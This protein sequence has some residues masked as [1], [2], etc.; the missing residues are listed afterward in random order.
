[1]IRRRPMEP[2]TGPKYVKIDFRP[3]V[4]RM[5]ESEDIRSLL[6]ASRLTRV[7][8]ARCLAAFCGVC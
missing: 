6:D 1:M 2:G 4:I 3:A 5:G 7:E 8:A